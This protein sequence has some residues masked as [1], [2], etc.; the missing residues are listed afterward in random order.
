MSVALAQTQRSQALDFEI[1]FGPGAVALPIPAK[2]GLAKSLGAATGTYESLFTDP[3]VLKF[4]VDF[5]PLPPGVLGFFDV[6]PATDAFSYADVAAALAGDATTASDTSAVANLQLGSVLDVITNDTTTSPSLRT[7]VSTSEVYNS[8]LRLTRAN[9]KVLGLLDPFDGGPGADGTLKLSATMVPVFDFDTSD[10]ID[11]GKIDFTAIL[12]H[13]F[14][15]GMGFVSGVDHID[16]AGSVD[17]TGLIVPHGP[18]FP[19]DYSGETIFTPLDLYRYSGDSLSLPDQPA[20]G[21]VLDW[22]FG[23]SSL[24]DN[25]YFSI[26]GGVTPL[27][28]FSTG[29][30]FG[31]GFQAQHWK[32]SSLL[33]KAPPIGIF[34]PVIGSGELGVVTP[35]DLM[36]L[37]VIGYDR[38]IV[39]E[40]AT[41]VLALTGL[42]ALTLRRWRRRRGAR[43]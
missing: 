41:A 12:L 30:N 39:P 2:M 21:S 7:R 33:G 1:S 20:T 23:A 38:F 14:G 18:D 34:D 5:I 9:Q 31:D 29:V 28:T 16:Y 17:P 10:G 27:A 26:D 32:D 3:V 35:M 25:P 8:T 42:A 40:P 24:F 11:P 4:E 37:D 36:A 19:F 13:E 22:A 43:P 6:D 15:H